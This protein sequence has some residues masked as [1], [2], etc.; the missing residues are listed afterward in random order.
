MAYQT[1]LTQQEGQGQG[2]IKLLVLKQ[3]KQ[4]YNKS[5]LTV[6]NEDIY[7]ATLGKKNEL[8]NEV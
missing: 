1:L 5:K 8:W 7:Q 2:C 3:F 4:W 6:F